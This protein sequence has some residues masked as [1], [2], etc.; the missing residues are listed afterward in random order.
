MVKRLPLLL[1]LFISASQ[2]QNFD[3]S[4]SVNL[5]GI[6]SSEEKSPFWLHSNQRGR[7]DEL[8][9][10]AGWA[11]ASGT[12]T[13]NQNT[14]VTLGAG[15]FYQNGYSDKLELDEFFMKLENNRFTAFIGKKQK[16]ELYSG[17][18][19]TNQN[20]LWSLNA[21]PLPGIGFEITEP[22][23][24]WRR[25][26]LGFTASWEEYTTDDERYVV[27]TRVHHKS[28][29]FVFNKIRNF[30]LIF[31]VQHFAQWGGIS[32]KYGKLPAGFDD[33]LKVFIGK[34]GKDD[35]QGEEANA[36]GNHL[37]SYEVYLNT[38]LSHYDIQLLYNTIFEDN[39]GRTLRNTPDGRYGIYIED[40]EEQTKW[41]EALMYEVY[42]TRNQSK[43][44]PTD[45][46]NDNYFNN[47][48]YR[49]GWT[50]NKK[51]LGL[52]FFLLDEDRFRIEHNSIIA[53]HIGIKG[54]A[55]HIYP[56]K[57]LASYRAN[58]GAKKGFRK[59]QNE[60]ISTLLDIN[61]WEGFVDVNFQVGV[62]VD[63]KDSS[64]VGAGIRVS[65]NFF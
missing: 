54:T 21:A 57:F 6:Y 17:L 59:P 49:S 25:G 18:S 51:V 1:F 11:N 53:H 63:L 38:S 64:T 2:A 4:A 27:D 22:V 29:H 24:I 52:P 65:K 16:K 46:G 60:I 43:N 32:P 50:Y 7:I 23:M 42:Y 9:S 37:G 20:I 55:G 26:G 3:Y 10:L 33:Y 39:S 8:T 15:A 45:D 48:L 44:T 14:S 13:L 12:Y 61:L 41:V 28:F 47:N 62:D 58:Y 34:E 19:A 31:G 35:V 56:Y 36:L 30:E 40:R 5:Q